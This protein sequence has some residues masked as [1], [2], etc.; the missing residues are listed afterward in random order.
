VVKR[1]FG[2]MGDELADDVETLIES[3][4][5]DSPRPPPADS[6]VRR[7]SSAQLEG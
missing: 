4:S 3:G 6:L 2:M 1:Y 7:S 5:L